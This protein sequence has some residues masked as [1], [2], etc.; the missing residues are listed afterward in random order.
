MAAVVTQEATAPDRRSLLDLWP[1]PMVLVGALLAAFTMYGNA[2]SH[3]YGFDFRGGVWAASRDVLAGRSPYPPPEA[4][5]LL[6]VGNAYI[7]PPLLAVLSVPLSL[8][9]FVPALVVWDV[10]CTAALVLAL[11]ILG[12]RDWRVYGLALTSFPFVAGV[13]LGQPGGLLALGAAVAWRYR[14]SW[15]GAAAVGIV[16]ALKLLAWPLLLWLVVTRRFRQA[17]VATAVALAATA[18]S[19]AL[20]GFKGLLEYPRLLAADV[21]AFQARSHSVVAAALR[22]GATAQVAKLLALLVAAALA[23]TVWRLASD[24]DLGAFAAALA[25]GLLTSP[26]LWLHYLVILFAP[27]AVAHR[28][29]GAVWLLTFAYWISPTEMPSH[30]WKVVAVLALTAT[31]SVLSARRV[32]GAPAAPQPADA[33]PQALAA[34]SA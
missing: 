20:I 27:L 23:A 17:G 29:A 25:F 13:V 22:L 12:V 19:W 31:L 26:I 9:P 21:T 14:S 4:E 7:A 32:R 6:A 24:R 15:R 10:A 11:R 1:G 34:P 5:K 33:L 28:R 3:A 16:I 8:L 30:V 18:G 2:K